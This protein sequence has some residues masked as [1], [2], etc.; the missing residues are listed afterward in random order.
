M[1]YK[2]MI[3]II[4]LEEISYN[5]YVAILVKNVVFEQK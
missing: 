1:K 3:V 5:G 2:T 4:L